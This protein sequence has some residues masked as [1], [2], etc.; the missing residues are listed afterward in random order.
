M[1][2][3]AI[4]A[5]AAALAQTSAHQSLTIEVGECVE[6]ALPEER[7]ACFEAQVEA[8]RRESGGASPARSAGPAATTAEPAR[9]EPDRARGRREKRDDAADASELVANVAELR[10]TVPNA[11]LITL[12]NGQI[13]RQTRPMAYPLQPGAEVRIYSSRWGDRLTNRQLRGF[14]QVERVR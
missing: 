10:E 4:V 11:Y 1:G 3:G 9:A 2:I 13:W 5:S 14:I 6:L 8:A 7:L 12:D